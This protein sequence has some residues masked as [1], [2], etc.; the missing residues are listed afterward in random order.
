MS[1]QPAAVPKALTI[2]VPVFN[3]EAHVALLAQRL[4]QRLEGLDETWSALFVDDGS[5]DG[6]L[7][8]LREL[9]AA[10]RRFSALAL[11]RNFGKEAALAAGLRHASGDAVVIMDADLQHPPE[12]IP[13]FVEAWRAGSKVVFGLRQD[14]VGE[15]AARTRLSQIFY[16]LFRLVSDTSIPEGAT[17]FVLLDRVAVDAL[18]SLG[19][20]CRFSKGLYAWI[21]FPSVC[22]PFSVGERGEG[23]SRW[24]FI[25]LA[26]YAA[27]G[28]VSFSSLPLKIWSYLGIVVSAGAIAYALYFAIQT[29][30]FGVD[31]PGFPSLI[32]S[33]T[34][35]AGVQLISL[36]VLG[37]YLSRVFDEVKARPLFVVAERIGQP[38][39]Q[40]NAVDKREN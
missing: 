40:P 33:I 32:V 35:F 39:S 7:A 37:E 15:S 22:V 1:D 16:R 34:F 6:T 19:E 24:S 38:A 29:L 3:E 5:R 2:V 26:R 18:N 31:V 28:F 21:G 11:S 8:R 25:R 20:R 23:G 36:G 13:R 14:R 10:D 27:D 30:V 4:T 17:D 12:L 9:A